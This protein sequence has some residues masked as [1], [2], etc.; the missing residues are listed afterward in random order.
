[1]FVKPSSAFVGKPSLVASSSGSAKKARYARLLPSTRKSSASRAG[2]SSSCSSS[3]VSVFG[4]RPSY[5][6]APMARLEVHPFSAE[7]RRGRGRLWRSATAR[8][9]ASSPRCPPSSRIRRPRRRGRGAGG[10]DDASGAVALR[11]D[12]VVGFLLGAPRATTHLG[13]ERLGRARRARGRGGGGLSATS[14]RAAAG[15]LGRR[16]PAPPLRARA[17]DRRRSWSTPGSASAFGQQHAHGIREVPDARLAGRASRRAEPRDVDA[18]VALD[19]APRRPSG[20]VTGLRARPSRPTIRDELRAEILADL[21]GRRSV[22]SSSS[23]T[24]RSSARFESAPVEMSSVAR[25]P[26]R[27]QPERRCSAW[28]ATLPG[29]RGLGHRAARSPTAR[30]RGRG[31]AATRRSSPTGA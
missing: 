20:R 13:P 1:M 16:G 23:E 29:V 30:S 6:L 27:D 5:R 15:A 14:T 7:Y 8:T 9:A 2:P 25:R 22:S 12:R 11:G 19:T 26:R 21:V 28:A 18:L 4:M 3:P 24:A 31:S 10:G 17:R